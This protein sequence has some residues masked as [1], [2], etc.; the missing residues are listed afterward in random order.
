V[1]L[2]AFALF[3]GLLAVT[4]TASARCTSSAGPLTEADLR[5]VDLIVYGRVVYVERAPTDPHERFANLI[6]HARWQGASLAEVR[7]YP[8]D[9]VHG[10]RLVAGQEYLVFADRIGDRYEASPCLPS[11]SGSDCLP[12][13]RLIGEPAERFDTGAS[14]AAQQGVEP[15]VE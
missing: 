1:R 6:V 11:C 12:L 15:D 7:I 14:S 8:P 13:L 5:S 9:S 4:S 3:A 10:P 2:V